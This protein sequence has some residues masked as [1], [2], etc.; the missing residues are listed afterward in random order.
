MK[1]QYDGTNYSGWQIQENAKTIQQLIT[2][3]IE[4]IIQE[5]ID[6]V[7][8]GRTDAGVH[9]LGQTANF[10]TNKKLD[11]FNFNHSLNSILPADI[12]VVDIEKADDK[13]HSRFDAKSRSYLYLISRQKSPFYF[14]YSYF[15]NVDIELKSLNNLTKL[16]IGK[17]DFTSFCKTNTEVKT[18]ICNVINAGWRKTEKFYLFYIEA[19]RFL[20]GMVRSIVGT[21]LRSVKVDDG[22]IFIENIFFKKTR[23]AAADAVPAKGLFLYK[24]KY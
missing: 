15:F 7:G 1:I 3:S 13:F 5:K 22:G 4:Q 20:Y 18:K 8:S 9:A 19:D 6:L 23:Q 11:L 24:I 16:F 10:K 12:A 14:R 2:E 17:K 21:I